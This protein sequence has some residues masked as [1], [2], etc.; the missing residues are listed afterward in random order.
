MSITG[1]SQ[2]TVTP[3]LNSPD[4]LGHLRSPAGGWALTQYIGIHSEG[5]LIPYDVL[6]KIAKEESGLGQQAKD[7]GL[8]AGRRLTDE[9]ARAWSDAQDYWHIFQRRSS[10]LPEN[11]TGVTLTRKWIGDVLE[12]LGYELALQ[13]AGVVIGGKNYP[14]SHRAGAS[15]DSPPVQIEGFRADLDKRPQARRLSPQALVQ[16][17]LNNSDSP[18]VGYCH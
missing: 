7:F 3:A 18:V 1:G 11:E 2:I 6:D 5:G 14:I 16:E 8:A 17:Y 9:I 10:I 4:I 15:E 13:Q 12:L